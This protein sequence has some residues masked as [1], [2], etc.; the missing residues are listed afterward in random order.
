[1][2]YLDPY[3]SDIRDLKLQWYFF[4]FRTL[5]EGCLKVPDDSPQRLKFEKFRT[6]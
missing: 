2:P 1:M 5:Q 6:A 4:D 3:V